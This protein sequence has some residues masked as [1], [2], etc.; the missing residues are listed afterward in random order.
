[1]GIRF[2]SS[3]QNSSNNSW[4]ALA[5]ID[6]QEASAVYASRINANAAV[7][8][9]LSDD[10][11]REQES[12]YSCSLLYRALRI[13]GITEELIKGA[14]LIDPASS[15]KYGECL[16][17]I[18]AIRSSFR[19]RRGGLTF[20]LKVRGDRNGRIERG[21]GE[22]LEN[23]GCT[24]SGNGASYTLAVTVSSAEENLPSGIFIHPGI[25]LRIEHGDRTLFSYSKNYNRFGHMTLDGAYNRA[26]IAM[27]QDLEQ[28]FISALT[29]SVG[30]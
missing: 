19:S 9:A 14:A 26:F 4:A 28:N 11:E 23:N 12:F 21:L 5:Y 10:A 7:L 13:A 17:L 30:R 22:L 27:E 3:W 6:K 15:Q 1:L 18:N 16:S 20:E 29:A 25:V 24:I 2:A 8:K